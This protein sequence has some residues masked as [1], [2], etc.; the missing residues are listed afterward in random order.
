MHIYIYIYVSEVAAAIFRTKILMSEGLTGEIHMSIGNFLEM[1]SQRISV[2]TSLV[3]RLCVN[4]GKEIMTRTRGSNKLVN[5]YISG[6]KPQNLSMWFG[7]AE[8][9]FL[10]GVLLLKM[11]NHDFARILPEP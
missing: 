9:G 2:G 4:M 11:L 10:A 3:G 8:L 1:L 5:P 6:N 7:K